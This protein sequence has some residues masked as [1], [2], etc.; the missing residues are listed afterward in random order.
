M[1]SYSTHCHRT[2]F[3]D[4]EMNNDTQLPSVHITLF[5]LLVSTKCRV[6]N[7]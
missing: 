1:Y 2:T 4:Y 6:K 5:K 3:N 7:H